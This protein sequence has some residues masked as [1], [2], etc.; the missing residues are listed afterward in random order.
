ME[1]AFDTGKLFDHPIRSEKEQG[2]DLLGQAQQDAAD[3]VQQQPEQ[4][5]D[6]ER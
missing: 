1:H 6:L 3:Q 4:E 2:E 5:Q